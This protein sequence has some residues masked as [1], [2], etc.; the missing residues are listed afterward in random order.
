M[1][2]Y[3][4]IDNIGRERHAVK[5]HFARRSGESREVLQTVIG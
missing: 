1:V 2:N 3:A 4:P 5:D